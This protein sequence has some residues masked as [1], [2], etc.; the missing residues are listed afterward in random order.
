MRK[1]RDVRV[2]SNIHG[3]GYGAG[4]LVEFHMKVNRLVVDRRR[5][6][7]KRM[8]VQDRLQ[9]GF[10]DIQKTRTPFDLYELSLPVGIQAEPNLHGPLLFAS[11]HR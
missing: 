11:A 8:R 10:I 3:S 6:G 1:R 2:D 9:T 7:G 4:R 5:E